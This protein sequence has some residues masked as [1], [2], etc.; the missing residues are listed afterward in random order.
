MDYLIGGI[1]LIY[2]IFILAIIVLTIMLLVVPYKMATKRGRNSIGWTI[3]SFFFPFM[4]II[5]LACLGETDWQRMK[6]IEEEEE[7]RMALRKRYKDQNL[8]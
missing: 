4:G 6:R 8:L 7:W 5:F 2:F 1:A 3:F